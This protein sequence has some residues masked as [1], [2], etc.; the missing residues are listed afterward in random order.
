MKRECLFGRPESQQAQ[1]GTVN[2]S[3]FVGD[4]LKRELLRMV[5]LCSLDL[6]VCDGDDVVGSG[7]YA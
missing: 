4:H 3:N 2:R 1:Y 5:G 7:S 6:A